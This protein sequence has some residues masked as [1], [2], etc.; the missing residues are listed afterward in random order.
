MA[1]V[2][3]SRC[4]GCAIRIDFAD[5]RL[6]LRVP[7]IP[8]I[9]APQLRDRSRIADSDKTSHRPL[10]SRTSSPR[11]GSDGAVRSNAARYLLC[12]RQNYFVLVTGATNRAQL[13]W[14][15]VEFRLRA[16]LAPHQFSKVD[17]CSALAP[18]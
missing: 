12:G 17:I 14:K 2:A 7:P 1:S 15:G 9:S 13:G 8:R 10:A 4:K 16:F 5:C 18:R 6:G 11:V 3:E